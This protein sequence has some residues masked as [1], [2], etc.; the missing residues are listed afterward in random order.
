MVRVLDTVS[1]TSRTLPARS[2]SRS[3]SAARTS[4][5]PSPSCGS[6]AGSCAGSGRIGRRARRAGR[7]GRR[8]PPPVASAVPEPRPRRARA[9]APRRRARA[10]PRLRRARRC[11]AA[12]TAAAPPVAWR[13]EGSFAAERERGTRRA[14]APPCARCRRPLRARVG[15]RT[16]L[17]APVERAQ[18]GARVAIRLE[19]AHASPPGACRAPRN[20]AQTAARERHQR[21]HAALADPQRPRHLRRVESLEVAQHEGLALARRERAAA[22]GRARA[23][24]RHARRPRS[25]PG[26]PA[27]RGARARAPPP[28]GASPCAAAGRDSG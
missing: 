20:I 5:S 17:Q 11:V 6:R 3:G 8:R 13:R 14:S 12:R 28:R 26:A 7:P 24:P 27:R 19:R 15:E 18:L 25:G 10:A 22:R 1:R 23:R 9:R 4:T 2:S 21:A 16:R